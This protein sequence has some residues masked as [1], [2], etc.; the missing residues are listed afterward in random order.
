MAED[1]RAGKNLRWARHVAGVQE[2]VADGRPVTDIGHAMWEEDKKR[3]EKVCK[4]YVLQYVPS[5]NC[6][7]DEEAFEMCLK[8]FGRTR[9]NMELKAAWCDKRE[10]WNTATCVYCPAALS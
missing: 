4:N 2:E 6:A 3:A 1:A 9:G 5:G 7:T 8:R 10:D